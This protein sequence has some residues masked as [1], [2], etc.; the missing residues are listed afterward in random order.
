MAA[1]VE[2]VAE[3]GERDFLSGC[4]PSWQHFFSQERG[5]L[6]RKWEVSG[7]RCISTRIP[8]RS[9]RTRED[10][11]EEEEEEEENEGGCFGSLARHRAARLGPLKAASSIRPGAT[12][13]PQKR[14]TAQSMRRRSEWWNRGLSSDRGF[15]GKTNRG[16][17]RQQAL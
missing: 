4:C 3:G 12:R 1:T 7:S 11:E 8:R 6:S 13:R 5:R 2:L 17:G 15:S 10:E 16:G 14:R 9:E